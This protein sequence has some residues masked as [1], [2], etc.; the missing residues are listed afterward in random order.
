M[1][2]T[3]R[4]T[5]SRPHLGKGV[6]S[7]APTAK[8]GRKTKLNDD[9]QTSII[10][11]IRRGSFDWVAAEA[12]GISRRT[13]YDWIEQGEK[14]A[15][16][17]SHFSHEVAKARAQARQSAEARV[18]RA[19]PFAWLRFGPGRD[20]ADEPGWT[21]TSKTEL[22]TKGPLP[23]RIVPYQEAIDALKPP[24]DGLETDASTSSQ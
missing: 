17:F 6:L 19:N 4:A 5:K 23:I 15:A 2:Q 22:T 14:G 13:F 11:A 24:D 12:A 18:H 10:K 9:V 8:R 1:S 16:E 20:R 21:E 3:P 7:N